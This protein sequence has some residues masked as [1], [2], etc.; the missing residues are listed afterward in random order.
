MI[1]N[2]QVSIYKMMV[3]VI[4]EQLHMVVNQVK[5]NIDDVYDFCKILIYVKLK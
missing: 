2:E 3:I 5:G 4:Y 1:D